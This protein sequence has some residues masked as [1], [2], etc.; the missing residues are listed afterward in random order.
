MDDAT[1]ASKELM[2][3]SVNH[4]SAQW[5]AMIDGA[6]SITF[7]AFSAWVGLAALL[8][9]ADGEA[10]R[11][12]EAALS[13]QPRQP[14]IVC[15]QAGDLNTGAFDPFGAAIPLAKRGGAGVHLPG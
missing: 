8:S 14:T 7:S 12:L 9:G 15:L 3:S 4:L 13:N 2:V 5:S 10:R 1:R 6:E 11:E